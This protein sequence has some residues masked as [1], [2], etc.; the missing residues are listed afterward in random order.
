MWL[1]MSTPEFRDWARVLLAWRN[2]PAQ[3][4]GEVPPLSIQDLPDVRLLTP[5]DIAGGS[6]LT[7]NVWMGDS[8]TVVTV[9]IAG[10]AAQR[11]ERTQQ[12]RGAPSH[13]GADFPT[14]SPLHTPPPVTP[15][16]NP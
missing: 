11:M 4:R 7:A 5:Q 14:P 1:S 15:P 8:D 16:P 2:S 12:A 3:K 13:V 9:S 6:W 10:G